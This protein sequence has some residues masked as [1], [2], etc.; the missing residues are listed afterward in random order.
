MWAIRSAVLAGV[1][2]MAGGTAFAEE[3]IGVV[4]RAKGDVR[5]ERSGEHL[6]ASKG[7]LIQRGDRVIT[8]ADGYAS[9]TM[10]RAAPITLGPGND[11]ALDRF[12]GDEGP[13]VTRPAPP[14]LQGLASFFAVNR[15]R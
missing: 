11:V 2:A 5:I 6:P 1:L 8:G 3:P 12:A 10:R 7:S 13:T 4:K 9:V 14:I 15:Q